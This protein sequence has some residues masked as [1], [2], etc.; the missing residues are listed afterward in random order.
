MRKHFFGFSVLAGSLQILVTLSPASARPARLVLDINRETTLSS[1]GVPEIAAGSE[2]VLFSGCTD[3][4]GCELWTTNGTPAGTTMLADLMPGP[5]SSSPTGFARVGTYTLFWGFGGALDR[6][7][8]RTDGTPE[9]TAKLWPLP[10][11]IFGSQPLRFVEAGGIHY[12][13][14]RVG[15][16]RAILWRTDGTAE[17]T[18]FVA[19]GID[20]AFMPEGG[21]YVGVKDTLFFNALGGIWKTDGT[22]NGTVSVI[23]NP[24]RVLAMTDCGGRLAFLADGIYPDRF[25]WISDGTTSG[26]HVIKTWEGREGDFGLLPLGGLLYFSACEP[27]TGCELWQTDGTAMGT[28]LAADVYP[29]MNGGYPRAFVAAGGRLFFLGERSGSGIFVFDPVSR[30]VEQLITL[31]IGVPYFLSL[32]P[33]D[34]ALL[35]QARGYYPVETAAPTSAL[36]FSDGTPRGTF[37]IPGPDRKPAVP[38]SNLSERSRD[39]L[40]GLWIGETWGLWSVDKATGYLRPVNNQ[41]EQ[42]K[43]SEPSNFTSMNG[44]EYFQA[45]EGLY[46][47]RLWRTD[48]TPAHTS[49]VTDVSLRAT[50]PDYR[51]GTAV[52]RNRLFFEGCDDDHGCELW[53]TDGTESGTKMISDVRPGSSSSNPDILGA[54]GDDLFFATWASDGWHDVLWQSDGSPE[55]TRPLS[56]DVFWLGGFTVAPDGSVLFAGGTGSIACGLARADPRLATMTILRTDVCPG[57]GLPFHGRVFF[58]S[59]ILWTT[60]GTPDGTVPFVDGQGA[61]VPAGPMAATPQHI[62]FMSSYGS[63][64]LSAVWQTDGS[65]EGTKFISGLPQP[66]YEIG[67][68]FEMATVGETLFFTWS[69]AEHGSELWKSDGTAEGTGLVK[70]IRPGAVGSQPHALTSAGGRLYFVASD[71]LHGAELWT[72]DGT[73]AGTVMVQDI[74]PGAA[75]SNPDELTPSCAGLYFTADDGL[76]GREPWLLPLPAGEGG[77]PGCRRLVSGPPTGVPVRRR[78]E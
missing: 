71:G 22:R 61:H 55:G 40:V 59:A 41:I 8:W 9:G 43:G 45:D 7:L 17:G 53:N 31:N 76:V 65:P 39:V 66:T 63:G 62:F 12:F 77:E 2:S 52:I 29:G 73:E 4:S 64:Y 38:T 50:T 13:T 36:I 57:Q 75:S 70:D 24:G 34:G 30:A 67:Q 78:K 58:T 25:L 1:L 10:N 44:F 20:G 51:S 56:G 19:N 23:P 32:A 69:D 33:L 15:D 5:A 3:E 47:R 46:A 6:E 21:L 42:T 54:S 72:S 14:S 68:T 26:S 48:G 35:L 37:F 18:N 74:A 28:S 49:R 16:G 11:H 60:D 27:A